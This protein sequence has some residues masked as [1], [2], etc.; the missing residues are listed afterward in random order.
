MEELENIN[1]EIVND[2]KFDFKTFFQN[3]KES[4]YSIIFYVFG[5]I[6]GSYFYAV[7][8]SEA[9]NTVLTEVTK[10]FSVA[11]VANLMLY[12]SLFLLIV[13]MGFSLIGFAVMN[14]IPVIAGIFYGMKCACYFSLYSGKGIGYILLLIAPVSALLISLIV[15]ALS[16]NSK[17]S[18]T[19]YEAVKNKNRDN[20]FSVKSLLIEII[21]QLVLFS[22]L[23]VINASL[24]VGLENIITI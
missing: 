8:K 19:I 13:L 23:A 22:A 4:V 15:Y 24:S 1:F 2:E 16:C 18:K 21:I 20:T 9:V 17:L 11:V 10:S 14:F 3:N 7:S 12:L 6:L 5:L